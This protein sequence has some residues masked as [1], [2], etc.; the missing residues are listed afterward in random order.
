M[1]YE[2]RLR[3]KTLGQVASHLI[4]E[5]AGVGGGIITA[6]FVSRQIQNRIKSDAN[7]VTTTD[8]IEAWGGSNAPKV[9]GWYLLRHYAAK[10]KGNMQVLLS[11]ASKAFAGMAV[12]DT[13]VR[14]ANQG[15][16]PASVK[17][18][19][20]EILGGSNKTKSTNTGDIHK[21][22]RE[23]SS[24]RGELN[25]ALERLAETPNTPIINV[26]PNPVQ[27]EPDL[28]RQTKYGFSDGGESLDEAEDRRRR[29][30]FMPTHNAPPAVHEREKRYG[31]ATAG[32]VTE[33]I[34]TNFGML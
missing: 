11:D 9:A 23:N 13:L 15:T 31:F 4:V 24:L 18:G 33:N 16:N 29:H 22:I 5:G 12:F 10:S 6:A 3:D 21:L 32:G 20:Y 7:I 26:N 14:V 30:S 34:G 25:K 19:K 1:E 27:M 28:Q 8:K 17:I 2:E